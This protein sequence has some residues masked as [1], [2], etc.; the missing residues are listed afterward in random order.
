MEPIRVLIVDDHALFRRG[1]VSALEG[2]G[3]IRIVGEAA[4]GLLAIEKAEKIVPDVILMD[5]NMP[6]CTGLEATQALQTKMPQ[7][8]ILVLTVSDKEADLFAAMKFG[9]KGYILKNTDPEELIRAIQHIAQG[10]VIVSPL[11]ASKLLAEFK[12]PTPTP[13]KAVAGAGESLVSPREEEV[14]GLVAQGATNKEIAD[15][16]FISENTVKT[17][18]RS[19]MEKLH[20]ANRSQAVAYAIKKGLAQDKSGESKTS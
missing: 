4:D 7:V 9:A 3:T 1:I 5:L 6:N 8:N 18:L 10:G 15:A 12:N 13:E 16:L 20:L 2:E 17:H 14:L 11:M 19:I